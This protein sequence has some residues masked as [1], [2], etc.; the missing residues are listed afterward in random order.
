MKENQVALSENRDDFNAS[1]E[2]PKKKS[3]YFGSKN[4]FNSNNSGGFN[5]SL[6]D[7]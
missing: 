2:N 7:L 5:T 4:S 1:V 6:Q 3:N